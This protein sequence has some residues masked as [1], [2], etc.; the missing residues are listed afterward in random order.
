MPRSSRQWGCWPFEEQELLLRAALLEDRDALEAW[1]TRQR[2]RSLAAIDAGSRRLLP[3]V[4]RNLA[5]RGAS[6]PALEQA[7]AM[8]KR[9]WVA[10]N[11]LI[12]RVAMLLRAFRTSGVETMVLK[13]LPLALQYYKDVGRRPMADVDL[14]VPSSR[15][16]EALGIVRAA[17]FH[18]KDDLAQWPPRFTASRG[19]QDSAGLE[20]DLHCHVLHE[21]LRDGADDDFWAAAHPLEIGGVT[22]CALCPADQLLHVVVHGLR[23]SLVPPVRWV[24]D[25][26]TVIRTSGADLDWDRLVAQVY[27]RQVVRIVASG[28]RYL[29]SRFDI[30]V[31]P[32]V[33]RALD[34]ARTSLTERAEHW[35]RSG[36]GPIRLSVEVWCDYARSAG[37]EPRWRG[38]FGF[39]RYVQD[40]WSAASAR[41]RRK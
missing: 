39:P 12:R 2:D 25:A 4:Y 36:P 9:T 20:L 15:A 10:N 3:L 13:G 37:R 21:C 40:R 22:T 28:L 33:T 38:A 32:P 34:D 24:A 30:V 31:P 7:R 17:G 6:S 29:R 23:H 16:I 27:R 1:N 5:G 19:F 41:Q 8:Y 26:A 18:P 11:T 14:L 35:A